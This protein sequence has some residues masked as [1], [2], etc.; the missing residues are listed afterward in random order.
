MAAL[1]ALVV[2]VVAVTCAYVSAERTFY[3]WDQAAYQDIAAQTAAAFRQSTGSGFVSLQESFRG[4]YNALFAIPIVP[5]LLTFGTSRVAFELSLALCYLVPLPLAI[6]ALAARLVPTRAR[7]AFWVAAWVALLVPMTW[8]PTLRGYPDSGAAALM[9]VATLVFLEDDRLRKPRTLAVVGGLLGLAVVFRRHFAYAVLSFLLAI[10]AHA[11]LDA[12]LSG[13]DRRDPSRFVA[14]VLRVVLV[15]AVALGLAAAIAPGFVRRMLEYDFPTLYR[16]YEQPLGVL[17]TYFAR[18]YGWVTVLLA[19]AGYAVASRSPLVDR[20]RASFV[21]LFAGSCWTLWCLFVRQVGEHY[22]LHFTPAI[23]LG[24]VLLLLAPSGRLA[25]LQPSAVVLVLGASVANLALGLWGPETHVPQSLEPLVVGQWTPLVR[26]DYAELV[27][28]VHD[29]RAK[30]VASPGIFLVASSACLNSGIVR[31]A[32]RDLPG[33]TGALELMPFPAV[34]SQGYYPLKELLEARHVV[35]ARPFQAHLAQREQVILRT[36]Y[37]TFAAGFGIARDFSLLPREFKL[38][39]CSVSLFERQR[40]SAPTTALALLATLEERVP[41]RPGMQT[42][43]VVVDSR[44][45]SWLS[46]NPDASTS[47][48]AHPSPRGA[49]PSTTFVALDRFDAPVTSE[50]N[51][52]FHDAR[53]E[54][55]TLRFWAMEGGTPRVLEEVQRRPEDDGHFSV[56]IAQGRGERIFLSV[57]EHSEGASIDFCL[58]TI[59]PLVIGRAASSP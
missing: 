58:L 7:A 51:V 49:S 52:R 37:D 27:D 31:A 22:T 11:A 56:R 35:L 13:R 5:W 38:D 46:R 15:G 39:G 12:L 23:V 45:P 43:W 28:L 55:A 36:V 8:V 44:F 42:A 2:V 24:L 9:V 26:E 25:G 18:C 47:L 33:A 10:V 30:A 29:L 34:D 59:D 14:L 53:C 32:D 50:G 1:I 48:V 21:L 54:G 19:G 20:R 16:S 6:G 57:L 3:F 40:P 41:Q 17:T 4:D